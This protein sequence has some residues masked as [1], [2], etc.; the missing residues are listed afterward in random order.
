MQRRFVLIAL[1]LILTTLGATRPATPLPDL[2]GVAMVTDKGTIV[3]ELNAK[4]APVTVRNFVRYVDQRRFDG[5]AFYRAMRLDWGEQPNGLIQAGTRGDPKRVLPPIAHEP[6]SQTGLSH[7][8]GAISMA[9]LAPGTATGD[10]SIVLSDMSGLDADPAAT[11][12]EAQ[13]GYAVFGRVVGGMDVVRVIWDAPRSPT[14]G[15]GVMKGEMLEPPVRV[16]SVRRAELPAAEPE[17]E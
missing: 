1:P 14:K 10:F 5:I 3:L 15:E 16:V 11:D 2:V 4:Q 13:A 12:P 7:K 17:Q 6:T 8:A 9:R